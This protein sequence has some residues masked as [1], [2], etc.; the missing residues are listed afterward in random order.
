[1]LA[2]VLILAQALVEDPVPAFP[3]PRFVV[4]FGLGFS[5]AVLVSGFGLE[6]GCKSCLYPMALVS[7]FLSLVLGLFSWA[8]AW[9]FCADLGAFNSCFSFGPLSW[10]GSGSCI[11]SGANSCLLGVCAGS[12]LGC[13]V[14]CSVPCS[15]LICDRVVSISG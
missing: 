6:S 3:V 8:V 11:D 12:E 15:C 5:G 9:P 7:Q 1:M 13:A 14:V 10:F 4:G 2:P